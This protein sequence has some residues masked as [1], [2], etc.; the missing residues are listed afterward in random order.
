MYK[1][2]RCVLV[3]FI[4]CAPHSLLLYVVY[5]CWSWYSTRYTTTKITFLST[6]N[7]LSCVLRVLRLLCSL[8]Q[9]YPVEEFQIKIYLPI[10]IIKAINIMFS[11][12]YTQLGYVFHIDWILRFCLEKN[13]RNPTFFN[14]LSVNMCNLKKN[15][16]QISKSWK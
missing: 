11:I 16:I 15:P 14:L 7:G 12:S 13:F 1:N 4:R 2:T 10:I 6:F 9:I 5:W 8:Y 3:F